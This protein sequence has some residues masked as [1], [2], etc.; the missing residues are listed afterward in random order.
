MKRL[1]AGILFLAASIPSYA[2]VDA[3]TFCR[4]ISVLAEGIMGARQSGVSMVQAMQISEEGNEVYRPLF[5]EI[6]KDAYSQHRYSTKEYQN[7]EVTE[8]GIKHYL[9]CLESQK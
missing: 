7:K 6:I 4:N 2:D 1:L 3:D 9:N 5:S 8:F